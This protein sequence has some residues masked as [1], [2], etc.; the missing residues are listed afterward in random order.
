MS[1]L[2]KNGAPLPQEVQKYVDGL[3][4]KI[5]EIEKE[6]YDNKLLPFAQ[7]QKE[8]KACAQEYF[9]QLHQKL[10]MGQKTLADQFELQE[11]LG[12]RVSKEA[13]FSVWEQARKEL[14]KQLN[15]PH[16]SFQE[17]DETRPL[18]ELLQIPWAFM[19]RA[20]QTAN[21]LLQEKRYREAESIYI[22]LCF[23]HPRVFEYWF[24]SAACKQELGMLEEA[25]DTY[26]FSLLWE[27]TNPLVFFQMASCY[28]QGKEKDGCLKALEMCLQYGQGDENYRTILKDAEQIKQVLAVEKIA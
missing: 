11:R 10:K 19:N 23:L 17:I 6:G 3:L 4:N 20:Y 12:Q 15:D 2:R 13:T 18:Q 7:K 27:P 8:I 14:E 24:C 16:F 22:F 25:L 5:V 28:Y 1:P 9:V 21:T 26:A